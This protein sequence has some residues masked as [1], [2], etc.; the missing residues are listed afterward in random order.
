M[1]EN[2][3]THH[4]LVLGNSRMAPMKY[5]TIPRIELVAATLSVKILAL[6]EKELD[7]NCEKEIFCTYSEVALGYIKIELKKLKFCC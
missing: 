4:C 2:G 5:F 7:F 6:L 1:D 3:K